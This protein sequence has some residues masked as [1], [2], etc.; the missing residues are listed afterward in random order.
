MHTVGVL[1]WKKSIKNDIFADGTEAFYRG[2]FRFYRLSVKGNVIRFTVFSSI[3]PFIIFKEISAKRTVGVKTLV[4]VEF[5]VFW[6]FIVIFY[7]KIEVK[8]VKRVTLPFALKRYKTA[9]ST[10]KRC[11]AVRENANFE[12]FE[13]ALPHITFQN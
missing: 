6:V 11:G 1:R 8:T 10:V 5:T 12:I 4:S 3:F 2:F 13:I 7:R 9:K